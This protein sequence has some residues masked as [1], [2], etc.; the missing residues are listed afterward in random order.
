MVICLA[1][2]LLLAQGVADIPIY[3]RISVLQLFRP[4]VVF[5][6]TGMGSSVHSSSVI[7]RLGPALRGA[8]IEQAVRFVHQIK[9]QLHATALCVQM[10][11]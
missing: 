11:T 2:V 5:M 6:L 1:L 10:C 8:T 3:G 7:S 4:K 9:P